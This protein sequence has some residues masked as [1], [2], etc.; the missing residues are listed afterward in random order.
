MTDIYIA[1]LGLGTAVQVTREVEGAVRASREVLYLDTGVATKRYLQTL[2]PRVTSLY[3]ESYIESASR[4]GAYEHMAARVIES[5]LDHAP[6]TFAIHGHPLVAVH[7]PFLVLDLA[8]ALDL[9]ASVLPGISAFDAILADLRLDPVVSG[10]QMYEATDLL[11]RRRP[12][13]SDIP[14]ILWQIGPIETCLHSTAASR[15]ERFARLIRHLCLFYPPHHEVVAIFCSVHPVLPATLLRFPLQEMGQ[16]AEPL[17]AGFSLYLPAVTSRAIGDFELL[18][19]LY[20]TEHL[21]R[22]TLSDRSECP[23]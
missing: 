5:A 1:G 18:E 14:A 9:R 16:Y 13:Q 12:L 2:C 8:K 3:D 21:R 10:V 17:H 7:A 22:I 20:S 23:I 11:L 15:P 4:A 6:V 19:K